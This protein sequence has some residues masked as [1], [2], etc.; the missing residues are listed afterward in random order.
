M[1]IQKG[2]NDHGRFALK[3]RWLM[4]T[5][6]LNGIFLL[7]LV[8]L[9][10]LYAG[11]EKAKKETA[12]KLAV[13]EEKIRVAE[14]RIKTTIQNDSLA[15]LERQTA[16][17]ALEEALQ[18]IATLEAEKAERNR[19]E[20]EKFLASAK[21]MMRVGDREMAHQILLEAQKLDKTNAEI[22]ALLKEIE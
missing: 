5:R 14:E 3:R 7:L 10:W 17:T 9:L 16:Q 1:S 20:V 2:E 19:I 6:L 12:A 18:R 15:R 22:I 4:I 8:I 13:A 21:R 11:S